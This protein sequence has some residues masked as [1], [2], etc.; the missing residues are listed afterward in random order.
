[1]W[2]PDDAV[3]YVFTGEMTTLAQKYWE[4]DHN[5]TSGDVDT[6]HHL[7]NTSKQS[8][9]LETDLFW[10]CFFQFFF[11]KHVLNS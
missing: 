1:M 8:V 3:Q 2:M 7:Q 10:V 11:T 5:G 9:T 4:S 6:F